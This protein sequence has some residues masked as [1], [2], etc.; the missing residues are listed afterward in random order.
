MLAA[1][2]D[3]SKLLLQFD[4]TFQFTIIS[5]RNIEDEYKIP[6]SDRFKFGLIIVGPSKAVREWESM[7]SS[8]TS[9]ILQPVEK[10]IKP[11]HAINKWIAT[12][13]KSRKHCQKRPNIRRMNS[14]R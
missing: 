9:N 5:D 6:S 13:M 10:K 3:L 14:G 2:F 11:Y 4:E 1:T 7:L 8:P 12:P